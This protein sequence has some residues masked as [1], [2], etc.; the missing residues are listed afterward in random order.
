[1]L[2]KSTLDLV[3]LVTAIIV[4]REVTSDKSVMTRSSGDVAGLS[5]SQ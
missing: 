2:T 3:C 4:R 5:E 1:M